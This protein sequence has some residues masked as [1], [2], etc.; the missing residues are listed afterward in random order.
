M[1]SNRQDNDQQR[2]LLAEFCRVWADRLGAGKAPK[3]AASPVSG[4]VPLGPRLQQTLQLLLAG[5][6]EKQI[7]AKLGISRHTVH[8]YV[9]AI[10]RRFGVC[11]RAELLALWVKT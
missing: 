2:I 1:P 4:N 3:P 5:D 7:A 9:K 8:D 11:S 6:G 10:Y